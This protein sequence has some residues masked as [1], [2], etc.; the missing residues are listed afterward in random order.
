M[1]GPLYW[2]PSV[3]GR[4]GACTQ[5]RRW[6]IACWC[7]CWPRFSFGSQGEHRAD[8]CSESCTLRLGKEC[9]DLPGVDLFC[10]KSVRLTTRLSLRPQLVK[11]HTRKPADSYVFEAVANWARTHHIYIYIYFFATFSPPFNNRQGLCCPAHKAHQ[12]RAVDLSFVQPVRGFPKW[13]SSTQEIK[14][15]PAFQTQPQPVQQ[16]STIFRLLSGQP[17]P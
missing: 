17:G 16:C 15:R 3:L 2:R 14:E 5:Y 7:M 12:L 1:V 8:N 9:L 13:N 4:D 11:K 10:V 6:M